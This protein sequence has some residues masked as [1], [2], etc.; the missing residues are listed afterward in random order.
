VTVFAGTDDAFVAEVI[1]DDYRELSF[2][3]VLR[4]GHNPRAVRFSADG[5][6]C[7]IYN[8]LDFEIAVFD[9]EGFNRLGTVSVCQC[10]LTDEH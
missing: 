7:Y 1:D 10:P 5:R 8:A 3:R 6:E 9:T 4:L 2:R